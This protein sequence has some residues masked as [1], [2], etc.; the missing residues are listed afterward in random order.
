MRYRLSE[1]PEGER[2]TDA[3]VSKIIDIVNGS[4]RQPTI[5]LIALELL[6][7]AGVSDRDYLGQAKA[8]WRWI[9]D[10]VRFIRD[11]V[12][13]EVVQSP[14]VTLKLRA[15][16]CDD[17]VTLLGALLKAIGI[18]VRFRV[19]GSTRD[20]FKHIYPEAWIGGRWLPVDTT[21]QKPFGY[22]PPSLGAEK[23]YSLS[24]VNPMK[25]RRAAARRIPR[26]PVEDAIYNAARQK[27]RENWSAGIIDMTDLNQYVDVIKQK[28][29]PFAGSAL[30]EQPITKAIEDFKKFVVDSN[31]KS[32]KAAGQLSGMEGLDGF[33]SSVWSAVKSVI[34][35][36][37]V[38]VATVVGGPAVGA[39]AAG[40]LYSGGG[41]K[42]PTTQVQAP[43][44]VPA[45][46]G[47][48]TYQP[49]QTYVPPQVTVSPG[50]P[51]ASYAP[52]T[53]MPQPSTA[54][55]IL[56]SPILWIAGGA[57][58]LILLMRK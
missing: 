9:V 7:R 38:G 33:L 1:V 5:R 13:V 12:G 22:K 48:I 35:P 6:K 27:L 43:V 37:A 49:G 52:V 4:L 30:F 51:G 16:D 14:E 23:V 53:Y 25:V 54:A 24:G 11:T 18:P 8:V 40:V 29:S 41:T 10:N 50:Q 57:L 58:L 3:T 46:G 17:H 20:Q 42:S 56:K 34:K 47:V 36:V 44:S 31:W 45:G 21:M 26:K 39:A 15:G 2:G 19:I 28:N 55:D 32:L